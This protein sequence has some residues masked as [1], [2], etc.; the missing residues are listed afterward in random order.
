MTEL[1]VHTMNATTWARHAN[2]S[3]LAL[4]LD[5]IAGELQERRQPGFPAIVQAA[6]QL[7]CTLAAEQVLK[8][9]EPIRGQDCTAP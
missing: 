2:L 8:Q 6:H 3:D 7:R 9:R 5:V 4:L 1:E